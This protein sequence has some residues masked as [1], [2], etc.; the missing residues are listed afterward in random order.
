M[1][2]HPVGQDWTHRVSAARRK[3]SSGAGTGISLTPSGSGA[4]RQLTI[5]STVTDT[6]TQRS[7]AD[8]RGQTRAQVTAG[9]GITVTP[10]GSGASQTLAIAST[11]VDTN[12]QRSNADIRGQVENTI[13]A[14]TNIT[15]TPSGTGASRTLTINA[16]GGGGGASAYTDLSDT[17][18]TLGT[19]GQVPVVNAAGTALEWSDRQGGTE[20]MGRFTPSSTAANWGSV[21][22]ASSPRTLTDPVPQTIGM[23]ADGTLGDGISLASNIITI[24]DAGRIRIDGEIIIDTNDTATNNNNSRSRAVCWF[25]SAPTG[26]TTWTIIPGSAST[27][28]YIRVARPYWNHGA[29]YTYV[30]MHAEPTVTAG[31]QLRLRCT[32]LFNQASTVQHLVAATNPDNATLLPGSSITIIHE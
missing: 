3:P 7:N 25:D 22:N 14:G 24:R 16:S 8:I 23:V 5:A 1:P 28:A 29:G 19:A 11:V 6:N 13:A 27:S 4:T 10:S 9:T 32:A 21:S 30:H 15:I 2:R 20:T 12:T 18:S 26:T 31:D 17:P